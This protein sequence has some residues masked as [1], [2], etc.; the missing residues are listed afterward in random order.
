MQSELTEEIEKALGF[1]PQSPRD[2]DRMSRIILEKNNQYVSSTTLKRVWGYLHDHNSPSAYTLNT[3]A[4]FLGYAD[5]KAFERKERK[6]E[7]SSFMMPLYNSAN[8][9]AGDSLT[10]TWHP[11]RLIVIMLLEG[12]KYRVVKSVNAKLS[13][14]DIVCIDCILNG[15][16]AT[17][18]NVFHN[19]KGPFAYVAGQHIGG[20]RVEAGER[21]G[22]E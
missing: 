5:F 17:F 1:R 7:T 16:P 15:Q 3:L 8:L 22:E 19:G 4:R 21:N 13:V 11:D 10:L 2:F 9:S 14:G 6:E 12:N 18:N 20:V